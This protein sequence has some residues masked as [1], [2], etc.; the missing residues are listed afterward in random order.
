MNFENAL[1]QFKNDTEARLEILETAKKDVGEEYTQDE[2]IKIDS[3]QDLLNDHI[4][5]QQALIDKILDQMASK[6]DVTFL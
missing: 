6:K 4:A 1:E 5:S 3:H 2:L